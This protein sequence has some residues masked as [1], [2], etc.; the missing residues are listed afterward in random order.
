MK[1]AEHYYQMHYHNVD[2]DVR[3]IIFRWH[4]TTLICIDVPTIN[5]TNYE[6]REA[7]LTCTDL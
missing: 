3:N 6:L 7:L 4:S 5:F 2:M 1:S